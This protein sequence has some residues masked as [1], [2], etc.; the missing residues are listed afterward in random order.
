M[1]EVRLAD[2]TPPLTVGRLAQ[3]GRTLLFEYD[4]AF[5]Q[6]G[7]ALSPLGLP[8]QSG[9]QQETTGV[10]RGLHGLF[11]D[12]L[13]D[14][15]GL[16][17]R[18]CEL[19]RRGLDPATVSPLERLQFLGTRAMGGLT[20]HPALDPEAPSAPIDLGEIADQSAC[21]FEGSPETV[22]PTLARLGG[23]A[24]GA[25]PV[26]LSHGAVTPSETHASRP[27]RTPRR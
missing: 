10:F 27:P 24:A 22:L 26:A 16:R 20:Y 5:L 8:L 18:D 12:S 23:S 11:H 2:R 13:P 6:S 19:A 25:R 9:V 17:L 15:W 7:L 21:L 14:G 4:T 1:L 3:R